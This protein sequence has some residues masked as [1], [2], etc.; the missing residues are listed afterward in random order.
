MGA[1]RSDVDAKWKCPASSR[2][3]NVCGDARRAPVFRT[4]SSK[5]I[6]ILTETRSRRLPDAP[7]LLEARARMSA[8]SPCI[9]ACTSACPLVK[10]TSSLTLT[11][12]LPMRKARA[13]SLR[14]SQVRFNSMY[15]NLFYLLESQPLRALLSVM[16]LRRSQRTHPK[17]VHVCRSLKLWTST[18]LRVREKEYLCQNE[19]AVPLAQMSLVHART[20][21]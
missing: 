9:T 13:S 6:S 12:P 4:L 19:R 14:T 11:C 7:E 21:N 5:L 8:S 2:E 3:S 20:V 17:S 10:I 18:W 1:D 16:I 15:P